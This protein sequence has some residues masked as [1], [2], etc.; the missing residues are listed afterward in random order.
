MSVRSP[1]ENLGA[2]YSV[3]K[4]ASCRNKIPAVIYPHGGYALARGDFEDARGFL[5]AGNALLTDLVRREDLPMV[6]S[7][8]AATAGMKSHSNPRLHIL[9]GNHHTSVRPPVQAFA[10]HVKSTTPKPSARQF[11]LQNM[12]NIDRSPWIEMAAQTTTR[13]FRDILEREN[14]VPKNCG[15][16]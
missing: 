11:S 7:I 13:A 15:K 1:V 12:L 6:D 2:W 3:P 5:S 16:R 8:L 10:R 14:A 4:G 9:P